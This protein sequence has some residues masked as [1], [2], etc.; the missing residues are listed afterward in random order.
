MLKRVLLV[1]VVSYFESE[2]FWALNLEE[3]ADVLEW[4]VQLVLET[5]LK[6]DELLIRGNPEMPDSCYVGIDK[7]Y[8][9]II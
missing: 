1:E 8:Y 2:G 3:L 6:C 5:A 7:E 4:P 9:K